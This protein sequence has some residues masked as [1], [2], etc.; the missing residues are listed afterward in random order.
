MA[1]PEAC[2]ILNSVFTYTIVSFN[3]MCDA[4]WDHLP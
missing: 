2:D 3:L 1:A 4:G